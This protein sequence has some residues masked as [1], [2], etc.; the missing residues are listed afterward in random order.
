MPLI[1]C[2]VILLSAVFT[3]AVA[4]NA[5]LQADVSWYDKQTRQLV[6]SAADITLEMNQDKYLFL[7]AGQWLSVKPNTLKSIEFWQ[8]QTFHA[9]SQ[10]NKSQWLCRKQSCQLPATT[11]AR[12][13]KLYNPEET[14]QTH[15][16][17]G[18]QHTHRDPFRRAIRLPLPGKTIQ[19]AQ[20]REVL[21]PLNNAQS[22]KIYFKHAKKIKLTVHRDLYDLSEGGKVIALVNDQPVS[23]VNVSSA[24]AQEYT[25][26]KI[27]VENIDYLAVPSNSYL[28]LKSHTKTW[29]K[30]EQMHRGIY[31]VDAGIKHQEQLLNPYW[32]NN[33]DE[34]LAPIYLDH[35][36]SSLAEFRPEQATPLDLRRYQDLIST[37]STG[38]Y[39]T[40]IS[41]NDQ[42]MAI[43]RRLVP[44]YQTLRPAKQQ[45][46]QS[47][48]K[49]ALQYAQLKKSLQFNLA[50][51][52]RVTPQ[53][54]LYIRSNRDTEL[55]LDVDGERTKLHIEA[56]QGFVPLLVDVDMDAKRL[57]LF[58]AS[59]AKIDAAVQIRTLLPLPNN[60]LLYAQPKSLSEKSQVTTS[61][62]AQIQQTKANSYLNSLS[63]FKIQPET[64]LSAPIRTSKSNNA[65]IAHWLYQLG[66]VEYLA[67]QSP[68]QALPKLRAMVKSPYSDIRL[69]A[70]QLR[71]EI[72]NQLD[73]QNAVLRYLSALLQQP[74]EKLSDF[75]A[76]A[77]L[78]RYQQSNQVFNIQGLCALKDKL[79]GCPQLVRSTLF[80]QGKFLETLWLDHD[81]KLFSSQSQKLYQGL[82]FTSFGQFAERVQSNYDIHY[83][84]QVQLVGDTATYKAFKIDDT[85]L[86]IIAHSPINIKINARV[87]GQINNENAIKWLHVD[88]QANN[89]FMPLFSDVLSTTSVVTQSDT[90]PLSIASSS[91]I[92]L[93][94][95]ET[96]TLSSKTV[97]YLQ[98]QVFED[99]HFDPYSTQ[100]LSLFELGTSFVQLLHNQSGTN[101]DS[102]T[103]LL[104]NAL[105]RLENNTLKDYEFTALFS[106]L[107]T[108][109]IPPQLDKLHARVQSYGHWVPVE[110]YLNYAGTQLIDLSALEA[111]SIA[112]QISR[113]TS[114]FDKAKGLTI[115]PYHT[116]SLDFSALQ[117]LQTR[118]VFHFSDAELITNAAALVTVDT[119]DGQTV[120]PITDSVST[121]GLQQAE[122]GSGIV[123]IRWLNPYLSQVLQV[124]VQV[125]SRDGWKNIEL[126]QRQLFYYASNTQPVSAALTKDALVKI[127]YIKNNLRQESIDFYPAGTITV[128]SSYSTLARLFSWQLNLNRQKI[129]VAPPVMPIPL[130][131][132]KLHFERLAKHFNTPLI[133]ANGN[134]THVEGFIRYDRDGI[135]QTN[136]PIET[137]HRLDVG[138]R[139]RNRYKQNWYLLEGAYRVN[140]LRYES[141]ALN[142]VYNWLDDDTPW[143]TEVGLYNR[144]QETRLNNETHLSS[145][146]DATVGQIWRDDTSV[147]HQWWWQPY[148]YY[149]SIDKQEYL[150]DALISQDMYNFYRAQHMHGWQAGYRIRYQPWVDSQFNA[151]VSGVSNEDWTSLDT[152]TFSG[153]WQQY[154]QGHIFNVGLSSSYVFADDHRPNA[155]WQYLTSIGWQT[156]FDFSEHTAG[157]ISLN[158]TQDW[159]RNNHNV[160][161]EVTLG[162]L[163]N[164]GFAP[165]AHDEII[166][167]SLQLTH[168]LE[169]DING[170]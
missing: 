142:G 55:V 76:H 92:S 11:R 62:L 90:S 50:E 36:I 111:R 88:T 135:F 134:K 159:F 108:L 68:T 116:L 157:W 41:P 115:R 30:L 67:K 121:F 42:S 170:R 53:A 158:W 164:T 39:L 77:L 144:W 59:K 85:P 163:Q 91:M 27:G 96:L 149:T 101:L 33:I 29:V 103:R 24:Q 49:N 117:Q 98:I 131:R 70:W 1:L 17:R 52:Q 160:R 23:F 140:N 120:W 145:H 119:K 94:A 97:A 71:L 82:G 78:K 129:A 43:H 118:L 147:R 66:E 109:Q 69:R 9:L 21:Y 155:T 31:D 87:E 127:E 48:I 79:K 64:E 132:P 14:L 83:R 148:Y 114:Q 73:Q 3:P 74:D 26:H 124:E 125:L 44:I 28:T 65:P 126:D 60:E 72:L 143:Y 151:Q 84:K 19:L 57:T 128:P 168:F 133:N 16:W 99:T 38:S 161:L 93:S 166:F 86:N 22:V 75:A 152:V 56:R 46:F 136:D 5:Y 18:Y 137:A 6:R 12:I 81:S 104:N 162:N 80:A 150:D 35:D 106:K 7:P 167:E 110:Q 122:L 51:E 169:Q 61:L 54:L 25:Q 95:G 156:L 154:Y 15:V 63:L 107:S 123:K 8:G 138:M 20:E 100:Q 10:I 32:V 141:I 130:K 153:S 40:P 13:I 37:V 146:I 58:S 102:L 4:Q 139:L 45:L 105:Y 47:E 89:Y 165:F 113:H 2:I 112:E 34:Y